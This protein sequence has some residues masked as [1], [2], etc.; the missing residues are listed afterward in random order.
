MLREGS[1]GKNQGWRA[2]FVASALPPPLPLNNTPG[3]ED[4][5]PPPSATS[6]GDMLAQALE[7]SSQQVFVSLSKFIFI[8][9]YF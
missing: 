4:Y 1:S 2:P 6:I 7:I 5:I 9:F 8:K 3:D